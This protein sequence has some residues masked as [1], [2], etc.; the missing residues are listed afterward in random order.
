MPRPSLDGRRFWQ[1]I[2]ESSPNQLITTLLMVCRFLE[3]RKSCLDLVAMKEFL[4]QLPPTRKFGNGKCGATTTTTKLLHFFYVESP[5]LNLHFFRILQ[6]WPQKV[7]G[8]NKAVKRLF[9]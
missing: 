7:Q 5:V 9:C 2:L 8:N 4:M 3:C 6:N 1:V